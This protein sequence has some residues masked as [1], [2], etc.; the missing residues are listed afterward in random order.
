MLDTPRATT[1]VVQ[2]ATADRV[3]VFWSAVTGLVRS[4]L[5][6]NRLV[7]HGL[8]GVAAD[9]CDG[10]GWPVPAG[11]RSQQRLA[12]V[13]S[14]TAPILVDRIRVACEGPILIMKGPEAAARYPNGT[15]AF[16]DIDILVP[17][18]WRTQQQL[19]AGGFVEEHDPDG[20]WLGIHHLPRLRYPGLALAIEVHAVPK[21]L[22]GV[23]PP[24]PE[25]LLA[26][27]VPSEVGVEGVL[28]P[29]PEHHALLLAA[30]AWAHQPLGKL[31][32]LVDVGAFRCEADEAEL[33]QLARSWRVG[34]LW[35]TT[36][37]ALDAVLEGTR[38]WPLRLWASHLPD[39]RGQSVLEHHLERVLAPFWA[40]EP[41]VA[42][43]RAVS[44]LGGALRPAFDESW[45]EKLKRSTTAVRRPF[46]PVA[47][48]RRMLGDS[49]T[50]GR[51]RNKPPEADS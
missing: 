16:S 29:A 30:H 48:H 17:D 11:H 39:G 7:A 38:T 19:I 28:A 27:A 45:S 33:E 5:D 49:A 44:A 26:A 21:W 15:R 10:R 46:K 47:E 3:S 24:R 41:R 43:R 25:E 51:R 23:R 14:V 18:A 8:G 34:R 20:R 35:H 1:Q 37:H 9:L 31:R 2:E 6:D 42:G 40:Y 22:A 32:D 50:R 36:T 13:G 4:R 12:R